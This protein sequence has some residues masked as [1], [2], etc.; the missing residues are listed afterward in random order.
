MSTRQSASSSKIDRGLLGEDLVAKWLTQEG[1]QILHRRWQCRWGE[2]DIIALKTSPLEDNQAQKF[3]ILIFVEVK[4]RSRGNW[5]KN[6][7]LAVTEAK[8]AKSWQTAE[9]FLSDRPEL[10]DCSCRFDVALVKCNY[11]QKDYPQ[12]KFLSLQDQLSKL[13]IKVGHSLELAG[14]QL[15][16]QNYIPSAFIS[17]SDL[18]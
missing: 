16:L 2:L 8:Q 3:P 17:A 9:I 11:T 4:T 6:G 15:V 5:D 18:D 12:S 14:Y 13:T 7:L 1:W 10:A